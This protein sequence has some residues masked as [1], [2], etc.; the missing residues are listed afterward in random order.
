MKTLLS[1][2]GG[3]FLTVIVVAGVMIGFALYKGQQLNAESEAYVEATLPRV[4]STPTLD[5]FVSFMA[6]QDK[7]QINPKGAADFFT[8]VVVNLGKFESCDAPTGG[9]NASYTPAGAN[10]TAQYVTHCR[11]SKMSV[12]AKVGVRKLDGVW[13]L[14]NVHVDSDSPDLAKGAKPSRPA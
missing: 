6:E 8:M 10:I 4:F 2:L 9:A 7:K 13:T 12:T 14:V 11:F 3:V 5:N 1:I